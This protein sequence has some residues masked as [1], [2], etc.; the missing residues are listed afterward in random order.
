MITHVAP[1]ARA[2]STT[3]LLATVFDEYPEPDRLPARAF[4]FQDR[5]QVADAIRARLRKPRLILY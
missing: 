4:D 2:A 5:G 3:D 1:A